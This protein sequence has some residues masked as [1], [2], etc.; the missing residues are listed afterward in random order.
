MGK[1]VFL[2]FYQ[3]RWR[4]QNIKYKVSVSNL[5]NL[6]G[7]GKGLMNSVAELVGDKNWKSSWLI[8]IP[9]M[10][11]WHILYKIYW[12]ILSRKGVIRFAG[13]R[14]MKIFS[15]V[16]QDFLK[17]N[18]REPAFLTLNGASNY[19]LNKQKL[20]FEVIKNGISIFGHLPKKLRFWLY[21]FSRV[22]G[23]YW[24]PLKIQ[25]VITCKYQLT[26]FIYFIHS[27]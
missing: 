23:K 6:L 1:F 2:W 20:G 14:K 5:M 13:G 26:F 3:T 11:S 15:T 19:R 25:N 12:K 27:F 10:N 16:F 18:G 22:V 17:N 7:Q 8:L 21:H 9:D 4:C 24:G